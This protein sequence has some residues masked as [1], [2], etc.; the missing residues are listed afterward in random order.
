M[1]DN[2]LTAIHSLKECSTC[3][4]DQP[5]SEFRSTKNG[6]RTQCR[7]CSRIACAAR[8]GRSENVKKKIERESFLRAF[9]MLKFCQKGNHFLRKDQF[10]IYRK[11]SDGLY[12]TCR[13]CRRRFREENKQKIQTSKRRYRNENKETTRARARAR[14]ARFANELNS[15]RNRSRWANPEKIRERNRRYYERNKETCKLNSKYQG[16]KRR[17]RKHGAQ[18]CFSVNDW[19]SKLKYHGYRCYICGI[20]GVM[21]TQDHKIPLARGGSNWIANI[22]PACDSCN[23]KKHQ[24]TIK[25]YLNLQRLYPQ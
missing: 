1:A 25:E 21:L 10:N 20:D 7:N 13:E 3:R 16:I 4:Q 2:I 23:K 9:P 11:S 14:W 24:R 6:Y 12:P 5:L 18:G 17:A 22:G 8:A 15:K 19:N